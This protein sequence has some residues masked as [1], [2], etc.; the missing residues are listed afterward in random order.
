MQGLDF[1]YRKRIQSCDFYLGI[2][3]CIQTAYLFNE[4]K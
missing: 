3:Y 1:S 2:I 4:M